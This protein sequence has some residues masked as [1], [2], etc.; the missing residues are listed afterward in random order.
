V[1]ESQEHVTAFKA[2]ASYPTIIQERDALAT[3]P[4]Y[5]VHV[6][7]T[8]DPLRPIQA[9]VTE[10]DFYKMTDRGVD[11]EATPVAETH[12]LIRRASHCIETLQS[13]GFFALSWG[14]ALGDETKGVTLIGWRAV[15]V[16]FFLPDISFHSC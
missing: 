9:P 1:W 11:P 2:D 14:I 12:E 13:P 15:E 3:K 5:E 16:R 6:P 8:G 7:F 4:V 10:V